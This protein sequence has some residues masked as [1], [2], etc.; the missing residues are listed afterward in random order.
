MATGKST[1][2]KLLAKQLDYEFIDTDKL[3][4]SREGLSVADIFKDK[5]E[6]AFRRMESD[7]AK[8]LGDKEGLVVST[9]GHLMLDPVNA[10]ALSHKGLVFCLVATPEEIFDRVSKDKKAKR[11]L[12][13]A[14]DPMQRIVR[15]IKQREEGYGRFTQ[16][17]TSKKTPDEV[18]SNI[19]GIIQA[20][21]DFRM[22]N[23]A[24]DTR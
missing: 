18:S 16:M 19:L 10:E 4:A 1:V 12:L 20:N 24:S 7:L 14:A 3:I 6:Y 9:G 11:P 23:T 2:G 15:L 13:D 21:P 8:E 5:G 22:S 17:M